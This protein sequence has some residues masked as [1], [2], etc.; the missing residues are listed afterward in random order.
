MSSIL[1]FMILSFKLYD[2]NRFS[3]TLAIKLNAKTLLFSRD[4]D[5]IYKIIVR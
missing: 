5:M 4:Y 3:L 1:L 2:V